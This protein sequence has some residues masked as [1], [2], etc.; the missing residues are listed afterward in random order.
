[1][2]NAPRRVDDDRMFAREAGRLVAESAP[3]SSPADYIDASASGTFDPTP[4]V[5]G[6]VDEFVSRE[7]RADGMTLERRVVRRVEGGDGGRKGSADAPYVLV[8]RATSGDSTDEDDAR[9]GLVMHMHSTGSSKEA[10]IERLC[11]W[12]R[13]GYDAAAF[14]A[15]GHGERA[16][17]GDEDSYGS[18]LRE[19]YR[20]AMEDEIRGVETNRDAYGRRPFVVDGGLDCLRVARAASA[21]VRCGRVFLTGESLGGMYAVSAAS[22]W[23]PGWGITVCACAP[24]IGFSSFDYG[25]KNGRWFARAMSLPKSLWLEVSNN[26]RDI[27]A[28]VDV[29]NFYEKVCDGLCGGVRDGDQALERIRRNAIHFCAVNGADDA[30]NPMRGVEDAFARQKPLD[31]YAVHPQVT[32]L[33]QRGVDHQVTDEMRRVVADFFNRVRLNDSLPESREFDD[34]TWEV[35]ANVPATQQTMP[36]RVKLAKWASEGIDFASYLD[37]DAKRFL[38]APPLSGALMTDGV[39]AVDKAL[40]AARKRAAIPYVSPL[41]EERRRKEEEKAKAKLAFERAQKEYLQRVELEKKRRIEEERRKREELAEEMKRLAI[42]EAERRRVEAEERRLAEE[43]VE[44]ERQKREELARKRAEE[45]EIRR[46]REEEERKRR[47]EEE[48]RRAEGLSRVRT[49]LAAKKE[50]QQSM[51]MNATSRVADKLVTRS[52]SITERLKKVTSKIEQRRAGDSP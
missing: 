25:V 26:D 47:E 42:A 50:K 16:A 39:K 3:A 49:L 36:A 32:I 19:A 11:E 2:K 12:A 48:R 24:M 22:S 23:C 33:A 40:A 20:A 5:D 7:T 6:D 18:V 44:R 51:R 14:D 13:A 1:M 4:Y 35:T 41:I 15:P 9:R 27:P 38:S 29:E 43:K 34:G 30:R 46:A 52:M 17:K 8:L 31:P 10:V 45:E 21:R 37:D 28:L